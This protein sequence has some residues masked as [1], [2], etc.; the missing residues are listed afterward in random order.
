MDRVCNAHSQ[1][2]RVTMAKEKLLEAKK[3]RALFAGSLGYW[4]YMVQNKQAERS[5]SHLLQMSLHIP[6]LVVFTV[7][8]GPQPGR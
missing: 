1:K 7:I 2:D 4:I 6:T 3:R 5:V 8:R